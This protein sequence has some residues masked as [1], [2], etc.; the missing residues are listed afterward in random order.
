MKRSLSIVLL[1]G[2][3][4]GLT[5]TPAF[6]DDPPTVTPEA[7]EQARLHFAAG[8]NLLQDPENPRFEEAYVRVAV[9]SGSAQYVP[10]VPGPTS[11]A[12]HDPETG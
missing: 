3:L 7:K 4:V 8:V 9:T 11:G 12:T 6:A 5:A 1:S 10:E 2:A